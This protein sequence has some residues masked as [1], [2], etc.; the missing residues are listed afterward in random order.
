MHANE[1]GAQSPGRVW[2][3]GLG[4]KGF[5]AFVVEMIFVHKVAYKRVFKG[6]G[7]RAM[8]VCSTGIE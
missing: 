2:G 5:V 3:L 1:R 7:R 8:G 4:E 6:K